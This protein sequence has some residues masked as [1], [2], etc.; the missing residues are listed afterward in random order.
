MKVE[1]VMGNVMMEKC[2][3]SILVKEVGVETAAYF[4]RSMGWSVASLIADRIK[5]VGESGNGYLLETFRS[6]PGETQ[7]FIR[8]MF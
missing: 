3:E 8:K 5:C 2:L 6:L 1:S 7:E 4:M